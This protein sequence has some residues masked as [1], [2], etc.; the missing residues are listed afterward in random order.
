MC[1]T[2]PLYH[3]YQS[4]FGLSTNMFILLI[5]YSKLASHVYAVFLREVVLLQLELQQHYRGV[6]S[7]YSCTY[8]Q[9][10]SSLGCTQVQLAANADSTAISR[11]GVHVW[12]CSHMCLLTPFDDC[13]EIVMGTTNFIRFTRRENNQK[14]MWW[15]DEVEFRWIMTQVLLMCW[16]PFLPVHWLG[17]CCICWWISLC[18]KSTQY[19]WFKWLCRF[20][21]D[22]S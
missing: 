22:G 17:E 10:S 13:D 16:K 11:A 21:N 15:D 18:Q 12:E 2:E 7:N 6:T 14:R 20:C 3:L 4:T 9:T 5:F 19:R 1:T 8:E